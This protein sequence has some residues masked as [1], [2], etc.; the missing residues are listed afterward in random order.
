MKRNRSTRS[1]FFNRRI[2][3]GV[4]L[5]IVSGILALLAFGVR[6]DSHKLAFFSAHQRDGA[7]APLFKGPREPLQG[8][9]RNQT[10]ASYR[11][12]RYNTRAV[13]PVHTRPLRELPMIPPASARRPD[14]PEPVR[15]KPPTDTPTAGVTQTFLGRGISA[16]GPTPTGLS[17]EGVGVGLAGFVPSSVPPHT[18]G[19][20]GAKKYVQWNNTSF[21]V[22]D[23][24]NGALLYGPAAGNTLFQSLGGACATHNDGDPIVSFDIMAGRWVLSQFAV[25]ASPDFSHEC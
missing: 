6:L 7:G 12:P 24:T 13:K 23:K 19:R 15:P 4:F 22:F 3:I 1:A 18:N 5:I 11:G 14:I 8:T 2:F 20:V 17:F 9:F 21:A 25:V 16:S 10:A